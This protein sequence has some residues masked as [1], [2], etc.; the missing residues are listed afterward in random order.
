M[1]KK[2]GLE[3]RDRPKDAMNRPHPQKKL[4]IKLDD[5]LFR[6]V[7]PTVVGSNPVSFLRRRFVIAVTRSIN[8]T[9][10]INPRIL[11]FDLT[12]VLRNGEII[13]F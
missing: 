1:R 3:S 11:S 13:A 12:M 9:E 8:K 2:F 6:K 4:I 5:F 10:K 7:R